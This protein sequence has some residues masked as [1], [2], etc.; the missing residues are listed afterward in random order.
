MIAAGESKAAELLSLMRALHGAASEAQ[1]DGFRSMARL[2]D[3]CGVEVARMMAS[4]R[5]RVDR[6]CIE[7]AT[8]SLETWRAMRAWRAPRAAE[9]RRTRH[10]AMT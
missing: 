2:L 10:G 7:R 5:K 9:P 8:S 4:T 1:S 3:E 6:L